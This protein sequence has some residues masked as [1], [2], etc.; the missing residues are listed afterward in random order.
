MFCSKC[1]K[2][3]DSAKVMGFCPYCGD[4]LNSNVKPPQYN[5][6]SHQPPAAPASFA[7]HPTLYTTGAFKNL[8]IEWLVFLVIGIILG[9][10]AVVNMDDN[11]ALVILFIPFIVAISSGLRLLYRLWKII[12]D[13]QVRTTP[14]K[15]VGFMF[16]PLFNWYWGFVAIVGLTR[17]MNTYCASRNIPGPRITEGLALSW[18]IVQFLQTIPVLGWVAWITSLV[19]LII[20][21]K[22]MAW[23]AELII[24]LKQQAN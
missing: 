2:Q 9:I 10:V 11:I 21:F 7:V 17:D 22:Q 19:F 6:M 23:K 18:F 16:I 24:N 15:A 3:L 4:K 13:G 8:W 12:Q 1:G 20:I 14:G 5:N